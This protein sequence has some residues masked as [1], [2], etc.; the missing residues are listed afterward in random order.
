MECIFCGFFCR[1]ESGKHNGRPPKRRLLRRL[2]IQLSELQ[3]QQLLYEV[4]LRGQS[5]SA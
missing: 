5:I 2:I 1:E 4:L 3:L